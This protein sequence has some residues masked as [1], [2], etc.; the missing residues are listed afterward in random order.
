L[1]A[2]VFRY[3]EIS[4]HGCFI[5]VAT[6]ATSVLRIDP[7]CWKRTRPVGDFEVHISNQPSFTPELFQG[8]RPVLYSLGIA[9]NSE[10]KKP[11]GSLA[12]NAVHPKCLQDSGGLPLHQRTHSRTGEPRLAAQIVKSDG[13]ER[14]RR[15]VHFFRVDS[16]PAFYRASVGASTLRVSLHPSW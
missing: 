10:G 8:H 9:E 16:P 15:H 3:G 12:P 4:Y 5:N 6:G 7:Q 11:H 1:L 14:F 13:S 2:R